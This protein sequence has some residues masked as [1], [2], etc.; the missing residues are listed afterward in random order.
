MNLARITFIVTALVLFTYF[1]LCAQTPEQQFKAADEELNRVYKQVR[2]ELNEEQKA[3]LTRVQK[4]WLAEVQ[5]MANQNLPPQEYLTP[6]EQRQQ[7]LIQATQKRTYALRKLFEQ[8]VGISMEEHALRK[9]DEQL[10]N[11]YR[12]IRAKLSDVEKQTLRDVQLRWLEGRNQLNSPAE[13]ARMTEWRTV[14][15]AERLKSIQ[16]G[17]DSD[18]AWLEAS[19]VEEKKFADTFGLKP[20][21]QSRSYDA[22]QVVAEAHNGKYRA[23]SVANSNKVFIFDMRS[24]LLLGEFE[25]W[26]ALMNEIGP[27][28]SLEFTAC[29]RYVVAAKGGHKTVGYNFNHV[30]SL[31]EAFRSIAYMEMTRSPLLA[32]GGYVGLA[33]SRSARMEAANAFL[34]QS[35][36]SKAADKNVKNDGDGYD[37]VG[38]R[39]VEEFPNLS[40]RVGAFVLPE[41]ASYLGESKALFLTDVVLSKQGESST[42]ARENQQKWSG[43]AEWQIEDASVVGN[44]FVLLQR[45]GRNYARLQ[46]DPSQLQLSGLGA[47]QPLALINPTVFRDDLRLY[48]SELEKTN[49]VVKGHGLVCEIE[50]GQ[51]SAQAEIIVTRSNQRVKV[52]PEGNPGAY[53]MFQ[54]A[55]CYEGPNPV[56]AA[57]WMRQDKVGN[58]YS[59]GLFNTKSGQWIYT[60]NNE[61]RGRFFSEIQRH[62]YDFQTGDV[63][64]SEKA[65]LKLLSGSDGSVKRE[66]PCEQLFEVFAVGNSFLVGLPRMDEALLEIWSMN[67]FSKVCQVLWD[68]DLNL[69][70]F[71]DDGF[72]STGSRSVKKMAVRS[73]D[74]VYPFEQFDL[75][76][77]RPDIVLERLGAPGE[78]VAIAKELREKRLKRMGVTEEMLKPDFHVPELDIVDDVPSTSDAGEIDLAIKASDSKYP[79][80]RLKVY[81]NNVPVNGRDGESLRDQNSQSLERT[82]PIKLAAGRNKIQVSV[83]NNAGAESLYANAEIN[84]TAKRPKPTLYAVAMGVSEYSNPDWNLKYAAK[85]AQDVMARLKSKADHSYGEVKEL[86]LTDKEVTKESIAKIKDFLKGATI[87]DTVLMFVAGHGLL[88]SKYDYYFG[89]TDIDFNNPADKGIAFEEFDDLL[90]DLPSLK[91]SLLIDTCHAGELDEEEKTLLASAG[92]GSAVLPTANGVAVRSI[93]T[94]GMN[95]KAVEGA[96]GA[97]EWYDRLQGLFVDLRRGSGSTILSSSAGAEYALESSEQQNGLFTYAVLEALDGN[98]EADTD[99]DGS[100]EM[101]E[102]GEYVKKRVS[103]LTNNKQTPNTRRVNL[104]GDFV[105]VETK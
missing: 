96:R 19:S 62:Y 34:F 68:E 30:P 1:P 102:L 35:V 24:R 94:R 14:E 13:Q 74:R 93:G 27:A 75:R 48:G 46:L 6:S 59:L 82:I 3:E 105:L 61:R 15:L 66:I 37:S 47:A 8:I 86:L 77:N 97:S 31:Y 18:S 101:S 64:V 41:D 44:A 98:K 79:L 69:S 9:S 56:L 85:D 40:Q 28:E 39:F 50:Q 25:V 12:Q 36:A 2:S 103:E 78:A 38:K 91:K 65:V 17:V 10:N 58:E 16:S 43:R 29:G 87:D 88:D 76:L 83:L 57:L 53:E 81:V 51:D 72:Y 22:D 60:G 42:S 73:Y 71:C 70:V 26:G 67:P 21:Y 49:I 45:Q 84:C 90:A 33:M 100:I 5:S 80:E 92:G 52:P 20:V 23:L 4:V 11:V 89:T 7:L 63:W 32:P 54:M 95:V 99:K 55:R 104:E